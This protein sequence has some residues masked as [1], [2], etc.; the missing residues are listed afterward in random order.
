ME[1]VAQS[2]TKGWRHPIGSGG[3]RHATDGLLQKVTKLR[4]QLLSLSHGRSESWAHGIVFQTMSPN[5][6]LN[7]PGCR[8]MLT[9]FFASDHLAYICPIK[10]AALVCSTPSHRTRLFDAILWWQLLLRPPHRG[11][12]GYPIRDTHEERSLISVG[13]SD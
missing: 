10:G 6:P 13:A 4:T 1:P 11:N 8:T 9:T 2:V 3:T 5:T 7:R 12:L